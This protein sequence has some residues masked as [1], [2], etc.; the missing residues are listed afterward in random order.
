MGDSSRQWSRWHVYGLQSVGPYISLV[1]LS[2]LPLILHG[3]LHF[4]EL[5]LIAA[6]GAVG[7][8]SLPAMETVSHQCCVLSEDSVNFQRDFAAGKTFIRLSTSNFLPL[9]KVFFF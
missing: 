4:L 9:E 8:S 3:C 5:L 2:L 6:D 1:D 7:S